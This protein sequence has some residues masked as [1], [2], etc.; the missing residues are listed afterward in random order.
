[1]PDSLHEAVPG[2]DGSPQLLLRTLPGEIW[3]EPGPTLSALAL[4][5]GFAVAIA[6]GLAVARA[7]ARGRAKTPRQAAE[8]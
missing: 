8:R 5:L 6:V 1:M 2:D 7:L 3:N 4:A